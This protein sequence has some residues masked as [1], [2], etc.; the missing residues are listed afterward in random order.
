MTKL[1]LA[2]DIPHTLQ[3]EWL[4][5]GARFSVHSITSGGEASSSY[6]AKL[7]S[8]LLVLGLG[9][10]SCGWKCAIDG[11]EERYALP[12]PGIV[13]LL[14]I[15]TRI[16]VETSYDKVRWCELILPESLRSQMSNGIQS[17]GLRLAMAR[18]DPF[19]ELNLRHLIKIIA[20]PDA[21]DV[22]ALFADSLCSAIALHAFSEYSLSKAPLSSPSSSDRIGT[23]AA[24]QLKEY[25]EDSLGD[26]IRC[27]DLAR[28]AGCHPR[29]LSDAF[30]EKF[31]VTPGRYVMNRRLAR[32]EQLIVYSGDDFA[33]IA[34][35]TGFSSQ[36]HMGS[37]LKRN[38]GMTPREIRLAGIGPRN[39]K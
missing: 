31:G 23:V 17:E 29:Q 26:V 21:D 28:I 35:A 20:D 12:V 32:A 10:S 39:R 7:S 15:G 30:R 36:S 13:T 27:S 3:E 33:D 25:I 1:I 6:W 16:D 9:G 11:R 4:W 14:P 37:A 24:D 8:N 19:V 18:R 2:E 22:S 34:F 5:Q 38:Y